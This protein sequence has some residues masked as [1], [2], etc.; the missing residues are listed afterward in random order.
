MQR[1]SP[2]C[3]LIHSRSLAKAAPLSTV[4]FTRFFASAGVMPEN[5]T[6]ISVASASHTSRSAPSHSP[7]K[8]AIA[9]FTSRMLPTALPSGVSMSVMSAAVF[10]PQALPIFT[11]SAASSLAS[12]DVFM[13]APLPTL[14]SRTMFF[15]PAASFL[16]M[17]L[18]VMSGMLSTVAVTSRRAYS[19][20]SA[21]AR[22]PDCPMTATPTSCTCRRNAAGASVV[23]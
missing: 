19:F 1:T 10:L 15:E 8:T 16:L 13:N 11:I 22:L 7:R 3:A 9:S 2:P 18:A 17:M 6:S 23:I 21:G 14:T 20:L 12:A 5:S 4:S